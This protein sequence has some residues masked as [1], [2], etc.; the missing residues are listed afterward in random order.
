[1]PKH[2]IVSVVLAAMILAVCITV[3]PSVAG[4][5]PVDWTSVALGALVV[6]IV[7]GVVAAAL[8]LVTKRKAGVA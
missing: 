7:A 6:A 1:M 3:I 4:G 5:L 8:C 2:D